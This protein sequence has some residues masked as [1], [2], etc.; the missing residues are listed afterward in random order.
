M[1]R[2]KL[3]T[4]YGVSLQQPASVPS[5]EES[6]VYVEYDHSGKVVKGTPIVRVLLGDERRAFPSRSTRRMCIR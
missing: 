5:V 3:E 1:L 2:K 4:R 6:D